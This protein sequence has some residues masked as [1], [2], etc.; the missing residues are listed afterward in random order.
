LVINSFVGGL[1]VGYMDQDPLSQF[2]GMF[3]KIGSGAVRIA[4]PKSWWAKRYYGNEKMGIAARRFV[5][6]PRK[7]IA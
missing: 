5:P 4:K 7:S 2:L 6:P 3:R 1:F